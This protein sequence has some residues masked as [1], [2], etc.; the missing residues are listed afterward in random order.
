METATYNVE[1]YS[2]AKN[3]YPVMGRELE[4]RS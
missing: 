2:D 1:S 3:V 4:L